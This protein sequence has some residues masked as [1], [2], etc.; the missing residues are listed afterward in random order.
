MNSTELK[1][2]LPLMK[3]H[4]LSLRAAGFTRR[5]IR[6]I[7]KEQFANVW[8]LPTTRW[9]RKTVEDPA[10]QLIIE[11]LA[12]DVAEDIFKLKLANAS[13][14]VKELQKLYYEIKRNFRVT[15][16]ATTKDTKGLKDIVDTQRNLLSQIANETKLEKSESNQAQAKTSSTHK[17][18]TAN[19]R[20]EIRNAKKE[21]LSS[22]E[23]IPKS[24][25]QRI[26][27]SIH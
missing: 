13:N 4:V 26:G 25:I 3:H 12:Q 20:E 10:N 17:N 9:I 19:S 18:K 2:N 1:T 27:S 15:Q 16:F 23:K 21:N 11:A 7:L 8:K 22:F 14:R 5:E 6:A 24:V